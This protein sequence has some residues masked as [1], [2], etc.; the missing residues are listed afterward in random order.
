MENYR[1]TKEEIKDRMIK[2]ALDYWNVKK[3]ENLDPFIRL[4]I[5]ALAV[6]LHSLSEDISDIET[7]AM[8]RLSEV[9]LPEALTVV[10]PAHAIM[11]STPQVSDAWTDLRGGYTVNAS[12]STLPPLTTSMI[13]RSNFFANSQSRVS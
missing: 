5:E 4:L 12:S 3:V 2:T 9:L 11:Y 13:G 6:Q 1:E 7:R 8:R 10:H